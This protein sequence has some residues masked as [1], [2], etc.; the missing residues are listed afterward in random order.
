M[1]LRSYLERGGKINE[2]ILQKQPTVKQ[3]KPKRGTTFSK[4]SD[5]KLKNLIQKMR[6]FMKDH[7]NDATT[8][9]LLRMAEEEA[10]KQE[11]KVEENQKPKWK[12]TKLEYEDKKWRV[13]ASWTSWDANPGDHIRVEIFD[14]M[15]HKKVDVVYAEENTGY[16]HFEFNDY[17]YPKTIANKAKKMIKQMVEEKHKE[18]SQ[19]PSQLRFDLPEEKD[20]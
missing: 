16:N 14:K 20:K 19:N 3:D 9:R 10:E 4:I 17:R 12:D 18:E 8:K 15:A 1:A 6:S 5:D 7:P 11:I 13:S 2:S